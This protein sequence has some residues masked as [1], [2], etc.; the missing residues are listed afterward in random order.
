MNYSFLLDEEN[1]KIHKNKLVG[2]SA[3]SILELEW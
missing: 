3:S 1:D 2:E